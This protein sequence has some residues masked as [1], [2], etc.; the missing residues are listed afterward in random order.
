MSFFFLFAALFDEPREQTPVQQPNMYYKCV[1]CVF[2]ACAVTKSIETSKVLILFSEWGVKHV[3]DE[4][5]GS[6][7]ARKKNKNLQKC[8]YV[9]K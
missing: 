7:N 6:A 4:I 5:R 1:V 9:W 8:R 2:S 3:N